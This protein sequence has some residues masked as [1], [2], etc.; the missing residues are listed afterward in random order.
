M[1]KLVDEKVLKRILKAFNFHIKKRFGQNF[2]ISRQV[3]D[4]ILAAAE[5]D[6]SSTVVEIGPGMGTLT[7]FLAEKAGKVLA[8]EI[9][10][11]I[12]PL[13]NAHIAD[14]KNVTIIEGDVLAIDLDAMVEEQRGS[15]PYRVV[16][17]LPYYITTPILMHILEKSFQVD[18]LVLMVQK[19]V[20][21]RISASPGSK[22]YGALTIG[23]QYRME[24]EIVTKVPANSFLPAPKVE[25]AVIALKR[26][27]APAVK[28]ESEAMFFRVVKG[29]FAQRRKNLLNSMFSVLPNITK[30]EFLELLQRLEIVHTRRGE[31]LSILEMGKIADILTAYY[32]EKGDAD[33]A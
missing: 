31:T 13:L 19:E 3:V 4:K 32:R 21:E 29:A 22:D 5:L 9:D 11:T 1:E 24:C 20:A 33:N 14:N 7:Q 12:I 25:S 16:A 30:P 8:V 28:V 2:L 27:S 26:R 6:E 18:I 10:R 17:N 23:V 15:K